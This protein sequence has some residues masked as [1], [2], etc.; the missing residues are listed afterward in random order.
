MIVRRIQNDELYHHGVK[1]QRWGVRRYQNP[2]G[3]L[4]DVG[5]KHIKKDAKKLSKKDTI[6]R[7]HEE[8]AFYKKYGLDTI[9][10]NAKREKSYDDMKKIL[11]DID[12]EFKDTDSKTLVSYDNELNKRLKEVGS[13]YSVDDLDLSYV[14][15]GLLRRGINPNTFSKNFEIAQEKQLENY[16]KE[17]KRILGDIGD[18]PMDSKKRYSL[19]EL[20]AR[21]NLGSEWFNDQYSTLKEPEIIKSPYAEDEELFEKIIKK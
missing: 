9:S 15:Y 5:R 18:M 17:T 16:R 21:K 13:R 14:Q 12:K 3:S 20:V 2:D 19:S 11:S 7:I 4:T 8:D 1:G 6:K 10:K